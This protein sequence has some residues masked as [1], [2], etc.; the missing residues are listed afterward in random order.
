MA[1]KAQSDTSFGGERIATVIK[2]DAP[3]LLAITIPF[4]REHRAPLGMRP[5][6]AWRPDA[7]IGD[8]TEIASSVAVMRCRK[9][10]RKYILL[11]YVLVRLIRLD[12]QGE[13]SV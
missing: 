12:D 11:A 2:C 10:R 13:Q 1:V 5:W 9:R 8:K 4:G 7:W 3:R 6:L